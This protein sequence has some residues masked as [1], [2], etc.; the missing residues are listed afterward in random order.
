MA[1]TRFTEG[2]DI[3][4]GSE[5]PRTF[6]SAEE[7]QEWAEREE[8]FWSEI[9]DRI[10]QD[11][12]FGNHFPMDDL[13]NHPNGLARACR[14]YL[15]TENSADREQREHHIR[16]H[17][18]AY[19]Q[20]HL[21]L[22][23]TPEG[24]LIHRLSETDRSA[25]WL[26][27]VYARKQ[28]Y[29]AAHIRNFAEFM[30]A[31]DVVREEGL[32]VKARL[33][34]LEQGLVRMRKRWSERF[35][36]TEHAN[37]MAQNGNRRRVRLYRKAAQR[38]VSKHRKLQDDN[39]ARMEEIQ[40]GHES[41]MAKMEKEF[42][43]EMKLRAS[44]RFWSEKRKL[45][46]TRSATAFKKLG[47]SAVVGALALS[48]IYF[49]LHKSIG[50]PEGLNVGHSLLYLLPAGLYLWLL[51][52]FAHEYRTNTQLADDAEERVAM[53]FTFKALEHEERVGTE[54]RLLILNA[55]FRPH[56]SNSPES[57]PL[58]AWNAIIER[59]DR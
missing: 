2:M 46:R 7:V 44:E 29:E 17:V 9:A 1:I 43:T 19:E 42:S 20:S 39:K 41:R 57:M 6:E 51:K 50:L 53:V 3:D 47:W 37:E 59:L 24:D 54:E 23:S 5:G 55:L 28:R 56:D 36:R 33:E 8:S 26:A 27:I 52:I 40:T 22:S 30:R 35:R 11:T 15:A 32:D 25:A 45:N 21:V 13:F 34:S 31:W 16:S 38:L 48:G 12:L 4:L 58:P 14:K 18:E 10:G 49:F